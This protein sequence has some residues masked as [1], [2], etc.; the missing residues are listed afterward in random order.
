MK[1]EISAIPET[2]RMSDYGEAN[3]ERPSELHKA[4]RAKIREILD[5]GKERHL[6]ETE[7]I[8]LIKNVFKWDLD[9]IPYGKMAEVKNRVLNEPYLMKIINPNWYRRL[10]KTTAALYIQGKWS[11]KELP[12]GVDPADVRRCYDTEADELRQ[13]KVAGSVEEYIAMTKQ[14][15]T[16]EE[17][18]HA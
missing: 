11:N 6:L 9:E 1:Q 5:A 14:V 7:T 3:H 17:A 8:L 4:F 16:V 13:M 15:K 10:V 18:I 12:T 2:A